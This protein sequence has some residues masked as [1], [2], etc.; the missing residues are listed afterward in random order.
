MLSH[1]QFTDTLS[2]NGDYLTG[3]NVFKY[4]RTCNNL[5]KKEN[6]KNG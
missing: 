1:N 5:Q 6:E 4:I 3:L 2:N